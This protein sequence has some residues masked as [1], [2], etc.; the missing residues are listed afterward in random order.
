MVFA[1]QV[2][3]IQEDMQG[4]SEIKTTRFKTGIAFGLIPLKFTAHHGSSLA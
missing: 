4:V 2:V 3:G 1:R